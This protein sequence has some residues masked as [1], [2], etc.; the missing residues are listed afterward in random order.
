MDEKNA[1]RFQWFGAI[2]AALVLCYVIFGV[3][4]CTRNDWNWQQACA[5]QGGIL[6]TTNGAGRG[7]YR[8]IVTATDSVPAWR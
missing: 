4:M 5:A 8:V 1:V 3:T 2:L 6:T 7:C